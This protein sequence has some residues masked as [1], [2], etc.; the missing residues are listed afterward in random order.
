MPT[1]RIDLYA[2]R[3]QEQKQRAA[4]AITQ[5]IC[6]TLSTTPEHVQVIFNDIS[7]QDWFTAGK[8]GGAPKP[9]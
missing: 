1:I 2:G 8:D 6:E 5:V 7:R 4:T 9:A 3:T